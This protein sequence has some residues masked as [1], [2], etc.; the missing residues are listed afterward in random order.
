MN[1]SPTPESILHDIAQIQRMDRGS[2]S[3]IGQGPHGPYYNHQ[4]YEQGRNVSRYVPAEQVAPLREALANHRRFE[5]LA[6]QYVQLVVARTRAERTAGVKKKTRR[7]TSSWP[8]TRKSN[9]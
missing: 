7:R 5:Q 1:A 4:C 8:R 3:V 2:L 6:E 9:S